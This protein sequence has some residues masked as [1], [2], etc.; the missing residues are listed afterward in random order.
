[1]S[2]YVNLQD[3]NRRLT[4]C[5]VVY[6]TNKEKVIECYVDAKFAGG[7]AQS[8]A[9]NAE[10]FMSRTRYVITYTGCPLLWCSRL[11]T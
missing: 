10:N 9:D 3:I 7:W 6:K 8:D 11:Q 1:M 4:T 2:T 5:S